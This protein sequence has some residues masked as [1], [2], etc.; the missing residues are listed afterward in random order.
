MRFD[1]SSQIGLT[2]F[3]QSWSFEVKKKKLLRSNRG[4]EHNGR[5]LDKLINPLSFERIQTRV[6]LKIR[7]H[8]ILQNY[9]QS[10]SIWTWFWSR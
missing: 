2:C 5:L 10:K 8:P 6:Y 7:N 4:W 3:S 1:Q 9:I